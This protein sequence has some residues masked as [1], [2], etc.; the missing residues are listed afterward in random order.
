MRIFLTGATG[1]IGTA[2]LDAIVRAGHEV[3]ALVRSAERA[4]TVD[5]RGVRMCVGDLADPASFAEAAANHDGY[6]HAA[7]NS[8]AHGAEIERAA[9]DMLI[10]IARQSPPRDSRPRVF[11]YTSG[12][13]VLGHT[14]EPAAEDAP[15]NPT[16]LVA[17]RPEHERLV[18]DGATSGLRTV[19]VRPGVVYGSNRGIIGELFKEAANGLIRVIGTGENRWAA[20]YARD[21]ADLYVRLVGRPDASGV[22]HATD[23]ADECVND[24][25][26]AISAQMPVTPEIRRV[27]LEEARAKLGPYASALA[28]DQV[29]RSPRARAL[30]WTP[31]MRS[32]ARNAARLHEEWRTADQGTK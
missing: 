26:S 2:V 7:F 4:A 16:P 10:G 9:L 13:W 18:L 6:I 30:G 22:Y 23:E 1:Y 11:I 12:V 5:R 31:A 15:L 17:W 8:S 32:I 25:V 19:V 27:P 20:V 3:T 28:L 24:I 29:V 14:V 21:L